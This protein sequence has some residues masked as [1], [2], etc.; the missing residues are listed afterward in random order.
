MFAYVWK[1]LRLRVIATKNKSL[2]FEKNKIKNV[3]LK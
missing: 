2:K 1:V 3:L